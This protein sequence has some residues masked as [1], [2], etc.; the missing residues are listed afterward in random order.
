MMVGIRL[1]NVCATMVIRECYAF[2]IIRYVWTKNVMMAYVL[3]ME[4]MWIG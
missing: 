4:Q 2:Q 3:D 1:E